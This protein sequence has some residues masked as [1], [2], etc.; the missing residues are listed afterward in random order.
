[1]CGICGFTG[2]ADQ[3]TLEKMTD[4]LGHRGPDA[5]A[6]WSSTTH[7]VHFGHRRLSIVDLADGAQPMSTADGKLTIVYN[8]EIYNAAELRRQL[9]GNGHRFFT[10]HSD[11]EVLLHAYREWGAEMLTKL[12]G[13]WAFALYDEARSQLFAARDRFGQKP[14]YYT[15]LNGRFL[16]ASELTSL[17]LH[18]AAPSSISRKSLRKYFAY[19][20]LPAPHSMIQGVQKLPAGHYLYYHLHSKKTFIQRYWHLEVVPFTETPRNPEM[21]WGEELIRLIRQSVRRRMI[22]DVPVG[23]FLS[24]GVDSSALAA[25]ARM[26]DPNVEIQS[27][28][29]AFKEASFDESSYAQKV[30]KHCGTKHR[31]DL[32]LIDNVADLL[33]KALACLDEPMGDS[34]IIPTYLLS[35][36]TR[37]HLKVALGGD[38]SDELLG[39]YDPFKVLA[40]AKRYQQL[41][42]RGVHRVI[43]LLASRLPVSHRNMSLDFR[44]KRFLRGMNFPPALWCPTWMAPLDTDELEELFEESIAPEEIYEDAIHAWDDCPSDNLVDRLSTFYATFYLQ[45]AI[46]TKVDRASMAVGLE[47]RAP[48]LDIDLVDFVRRLPSC[49]KVRGFQT[50]YLLKR[51]L[52][53]YLPR[54]ILYRRK[55]GF[56]MPVGPWIQQGRIDVGPYPLDDLNTAFLQT[57][58]SDHRANRRDDRAYLWNSLVLNHWL[59]AN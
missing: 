38:G 44:I 28:N 5:G 50:K 42:P 35:E 48:M 47:A 20:Y 16:F 53:P 24:G 3:P 21:E 2:S 43:S 11:T 25:V 9:E 7:G 26:D 10:S 46:L 19:G 18:P 29:I 23:L 45:D 55:R 37:R 54:E 13:M 1:M 6:T 32:L 33:P 40:W 14:F 36:F 57:R 12:N 58:L 41:T 8:G 30:A 49:W 31:H 4:S 17:R 22:A 15:E 39:G 52:L 34:S 27:F 59:D 51:A 56:G